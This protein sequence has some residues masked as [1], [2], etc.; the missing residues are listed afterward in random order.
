MT[1]PTL[2]GFTPAITFD[3]NT[4]N[5]TPQ[6]LDSDVNFQ[7][8]EGDFTGGQLTL[9]GLLAEDR[10]SV[11]NEGVDAGQIG[12]S[13]T[14]VT[15]GGV[16]IGTLAGG[17]GATLTITFNASAT[18]A[19]IDA[20]IQN[21]T[22]ANVSNAPTASRNLILNVI[23][24]AGNG[25]GSAAGTSQTF[26]QQS[27]AGDP[28]GG[29]SSIGSRGTPSFGDVDGDGDLDMVLGRGYGY[30]GGTNLRYFTNS[31]GVFTEQ[32]GAQNPFRAI[33][34]NNYSDPALADLDGD[35][36]LDL[37]VHRQYSNSRTFFNTGGVFTERT[38]SQNPLN[39]FS[40]NYRASPTFVDFDGD[41]D[42]D[43]V[44][45]NGGSLRYFQNNAN[46]FTEQ[47]GSTNPFNGDNFGYNVSPAFI[48][49]DGDG[50]LDVVA[51]QSNGPIR[52]F[53]NNGNGSFS[54]LSG[55][56][57]PFNGA[58]FAG[59]APTFADVDNDGDLDL[60]VGG[61][62]QIVYFLNTSPRGQTV[63][64][65]VTA[66]N[67]AL[68]ATGLPTDVTVIE[69]TSSNLNLS[70]LSL[71]DPDVVAPITMVLTA[72][73]GTLTAVSGGGVTVTGS[74]S[75]VLTLVGTASAIDTFLNT[76]TNVRY[77]SAA[78][79]AGDN[80]ATVTV[81]VDEGSGPVEVGVVN[82][83]ITNTPEPP[84][85]TGFATAVTFNENDVNATPALID[86]EVDF[87]DFEGTFSGGSL[88]M[89]GL[90]A[91]DRV[92]VRNEGV[93]AGQIGLSGANVTYGGVVIGTLAGGSGVTLTI[94]FNA[95]ADNAAVD[96]LI[97]NLTYANVSNNPTATRNLALN[98]TDAD[99]LAITP[100][101][102][103]GPATFSVQSGAS[104]P[105]NAIT[106]NQNSG[107]TFFDIDN[108]GDGDLIVGTRDGF[109][110]AYTN[111]NGTFTERTGS[112]NPFNGVDIG[113]Y[114]RP[115]F[116]DFDGD[117]DLDMV[118]GQN[119]SSLRAFR[120]TNGVFAEVSGGSNPFNGISASNGTPTF[121]DIDSDGDQ[122]LV[123]GSSSSQLRVFTNANNVFTER[124]GTNNPLN[125]ISEYRGAPT[126]VDL[127]GD[128]DRDLVLGTEAGTLR[129]F[130]NASNVFTEQTG[131]ANP[132]NGIDIGSRSAPAFSDVDADGDQDLVIGN[133][134]GT[135]T[136][137]LNT[138][139]R[140][141]V[142]T[143]TVTAQND[144]LTVTGLPTDVTVIEDL[145]SNLNLS[146][147]T[148]TDPD[149][150]A[151]ITMVLTA[152][153]GTLAAVSNGGVTVTGS[154]TGVLTLVGTASA[155]DTFLNTVT[156]IRYTG[157]A[158]DAGADAAT[159]TV[160]IDEGAGAYQVG[161]V[162]VDITDMPEPPVLTG[163]ATTVTFG[164]NDVNATP[165]LLDIDVSFSDF[166]DTFTGGTLR[167]AGLLAE[168]R[169]SVRNEGVDAGQIGLSGSNVTYGGVVIGTLAGGSGATLT[170]TFNAA[171]NSV[172]IDALIQNL[173]YANVSNNPTATRN[174]SLNVTDAGGLSI[175]S[176][177]SAGAATFAQQ[178]GAANPFN[179]VS[180]SSTATPFFGDFDNDGDQD[181]VVGST[182]NNFRYFTSVG[183]VFTERTGAQ[184]PFNGISNSGGFTDG[185][186]V[187]LDADGDLDFFQNNRDNGAPRTWFNANGVLTERT[188][189]Q[190]PFS[191]I[192]LTL[193][194]RGSPTFVD[195]D[196]D[197]DMDLVT[198]NG[199]SG[200]RTFFNTGGAFAE[201][202]GAS[203]PFNG[204][205][206]GS[207]QVSPTFLDLDGD[208]DL[209]VVS[210]QYT[211]LLRT[212]RN[213]GSGS[214]T[215]LTG[216][217]N[218][219][220]GVD[221]GDRAAPTFADVDGDG[222]MDL[223]T[224]G[225]YGPNSN[226]LI[227]HLNTTP[228]GQI[229]TVNV[230]A[231][232]D[233]LT[234]TGLPTD[235]TVIEEIASNVNLSGLT[236]TD[237]DVT[238]NITMVLTASEGTLTAVSGGGVTVTGSASGV[239]TLIG[240]ASAIDTFLNTVTNI[241]YTGATDDQGDNAATITVTIDEGAGAYAVGVVNVDIT[242]TTEAPILT[243]L[244]TAVTFG[245]N[246]VNAT[247]ALI[248]AEVDFSDFEGTFS[249][250]SLRMAGIL[251]EDRVSVRN[252][253]VDA[254][255]IGLSGAN[256]TYGGVVIG[257]LAGGSGNTLTITFNAAANSAAVDALVQNLTYANVS[258]TPTATRNFSLNITDADGQNI[259]GT[260]SVGTATF[261]QQ[262]GAANPF[263]AV[264]ASNRSA[265]TLAD[266]DADGDLDLVMGD[267][268]GQVRYYNNAGGVY[269]ERTGAQNPF[270]GISTGNFSDTAFADLDGDGDLDMVVHHRYSNSRSFFNT[271]GV[272]AE[273]TGSQNP[274]N[275]FSGGYRAS[276]VFVDFDGDGDQDYVLGNGSQLRYFRNT[277]NVFSEQS[278]TN[279]PFGTLNFGNN[280]SPAFMDLDSD[281]DLDV[282]AGQ[283][284]G[285]FRS[286]RN[287]GSGSFT[288]LTGAANPFNGIDVGDNASPFFAD[289]D[290]DGDLD[291]VSGSNNGTPT[292][293][294]NTSPRGQIIAVNVTAQNDALTATGLPTDVTVIEEIASNVNLSALTLTDL[295]V[296]D[297][298]TVVLTAS[299]GILTAGS[300]GG[301]TVTG[302]ASGT[303][304]LVG[305]AAAIDTFLNNVAAIR[306][307]GASNVDGD[308]AATVTVTTNEG[309][310]AVTVGVVNV[311]ITNT[312]EAPVLTGFATTL[313][314]AENTANVTPQLLDIDVTFS[315][316]EDTFA[317]GFL[318]M[319]GLLA[320]DR[321]SVRN[322]GVDAGQIGLSGANVTYGG[323]VI[324]TLAGGS[325]NALTITFN[326]AAN[327]VAIDALI[328][329]LTY[330]NV[331]DNPT[332][333]RNLALNIT[334]ADGQT[335]VG[336]G[337]A[338]NL[339]F[340]QQSGSGNPFGGI[341]SV[342]NRATPSF[343]DVDG[344]GDLDMVLNRG[345]GYGNLR[346]FTN[347]GGVFTEQSGAQNPFG[348]IPGSNYSDPVLADLDGDGDLDLVVHVRYSNS[349]TFFN[350]GGVFTERTGSQNPLN[351]FS[352]NYRASPTFV[353][354]D[355]D[356]DQDYV[357][358]NGNQLRYFQNNANVF[359]EQSGAGNPFNGDTFGGS[360]ISPA[361]IDLDGD[362]DLDVVAGQ[363]YG[364]IRVFR[365]EGNGTFAEQT[366][367]ANPFN[368][369]SLSSGAAPTFADID[370]DG[371]LDLVVGSSNSISY[372]LNTS[373]RGQIVTVNV[374]TEADAVTATGVPTDVTVVE[375]VASN[376]NLSA[377]ALTDPDVIG[378]ITVV[379][380]ASAGTMVAVTG[381]GV[382]VTGSA[383]GVL[384]LVGTTAAIDAFLNT[385]ANIRYTGAANVFGDNAATVTITADGGTGAVTLGVVNVDITAV[386]DAPTLSG[387]GPINTFIENATNAGPQLLDLDV[388]FSDLEDGFA[389][390]A[391]TLSGLL[392]EDRVS[393]RNEGTDAGQIG[394]SGTDVTYGG[395]VI[396]TLAGGS[397]ATLTITFNAAADS[398]SI[399][400]LI[401]NLTYANASDNP[402]TSRNLVLN[403]TDA[404]GLGLTG[405]GRLSTF[406]Q[407]TGVSNP[408]NGSPINFAN[409]NSFIDLD[410]DGDL[411]LVT[412][413]YNGR[414]RAFTNSAGAFTELTGSA[415]PFNAIDV[416]YNS[417]P[418]FADLDGD[419]D[420]DLVVGTN[421]GTLRTFTNSGGAFSEVTGAANP[422][423]G[424][425]LGSHTTPTF[426][427]VD[428]DGDMDL[429]VGNNYG[430]TNYFQNTTPRPSAST[431]TVNVA[432]QNDAP[433][434][435]GLPTDVTV[436][437]DETSALDLSA[438][439]LTDV[440]TSGPITVVLAASSGTLAAAS[441]SGVTVSG[442]ATGTLTLVGT[443]A[444]ID[445]FLNLAS[446]VQ[447][448]AVIG[449]S[450]NNAAT[451]IITANDGGGAVS[452][453]TVNIDITT[454]DDLLIGTAGADTLNGL[455]GNDILRGLGGIDILNGGT[456]IDLAD[457]S[458][459]A[460][461]VSVRLAS[462]ATLADG[463]G[464]RDTLNSIENVTG[465]A[466]DDTLFGDGVDNVLLGG[467]G[468]DTLL[469]LGGNDTLSG[470]TGVAN[471]L[472]G[473]LGDDIY[474]VE[475][476]DTITEFA[477]EGVD[478]VRTSL[479]TFT[480]GANLENLTYSGA[481]LFRGTGNALANVITGGNG[482]DVLIG[483]GGVD[484]LNGGGGID[485]VDYSTAAA[486]VTA[487]LT[488]GTAT[489]DGD[490]A[491][492]TLTGIE[493]LT[494][495][496]FGDTLTG[497]A[498]S[499]VL[500]GGNGD[501]VLTG[502]SG[503]DFLFGGAGVDTASWAGASSGVRAAINS[504]VLGDGSASDDGDGGIDSLSGIENLIGSDF[505]D[506]LLGSAA[507]NV[508]TGGLGA[509]LLL[510]FGGND[511]LI[512]GTGAANTLQGGLGDD[513]YVVSAADTITEVANEGNDT[514]Q[515]DRASFNLGANLENLTYTGSG[516][517][518]GTG[519]VLANVI[520]GGSGADSLRGGGGDDTL[521]GGLG[522]DLVLV[523]GL[524]ADYLIQD[525]GGGQFRVTD[526]VGGRDGIDILT[527]VE[528]IRF[529][530]GTTV[531]LSSLV[532]APSLSPKDQAT[533]FVLPGLTDDDFLP[534]GKDFGDPLVLPG[535]DGAP[536]RIA[537][538]P[539]TGDWM[540]T[541][542]DTDPAIY[543][544]GDPAARPFHDDWMY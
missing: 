222:D 240:T 279:N 417:D 249:G 85:L 468:R 136:Y 131:S 260:G 81:T 426:Q 227:F 463:D 203:N 102:S 339:T 421:Y 446:R 457:Y 293:Y 90:L 414:L 538:T 48:D 360:N 380:T 30:I 374:T 127:D 337:S 540:L 49:L 386:N 58:S 130:F 183:G 493:N 529:S 258:H 348:S 513:I 68:T 452:L 387:F 75:G 382:T 485:L 405:A 368:G 73:E 33:Q 88:R 467:L 101:G 451:L 142:V 61:N 503:N 56:A 352:G 366:G 440:D 357:L 265:P 72:S 160:T 518:G 332:A 150:I 165:A 477:N 53:Q 254:G 184:N 257:T 10:V 20:L 377:I 489:N 55:T 220:N 139:P 327:S 109:F 480:L 5:S 113:Y 27:G 351:G 108:D 236:L 531:A 193:S 64:V 255:Q 170:I 92:S 383:S 329:N 19:A 312:T 164:E 495:S 533:A 95:A 330:A 233:A 241:R 37:V 47:S 277:S 158:N 230:T 41:G 110:R 309:S 14:D 501:D 246:D 272:F 231:Q 342:G 247:P 512:G 530:N 135:L 415:N 89:A 29:I 2:T 132:F 372:F 423:D 228:R 340:A 146:G 192:G 250:G 129:T 248:D 235:V 515:T 314:F 239:L 152:S 410:G 390:G 9:S 149:V 345:G 483:R 7:D 182:A 456:G 322:E 263:N 143:V 438:L 315:D 412:G 487:S 46:V 283:T 62:N 204:V 15:Y 461:G 326:A 439:S 444:A 178:T 45:S 252:E 534:T 516:N 24:A 167:L 245:E 86:A 40:G 36:D 428:G 313:T 140:G 179:G 196:G 334:D 194:Y 413:S 499:N 505:D 284:E 25:F 306:Y 472:Q 141:Q 289:V 394:L 526:N 276:P 77:T 35:G 464:G 537:I 111:T 32:T 544:G 43:Y 122:D 259:G 125:G 270:N 163:L 486:G 364:N 162:N 79:D 523:S 172:A 21:L 408:F 166:E 425:D 201:R 403:V 411:D 459:A 331:S 447:Y 114:A 144:A 449:V 488:D 388:S 510:G 450:G 299:T 173:T 34:G 525:L 198:N 432:P 292:Y 103:A 74:A 216:S 4:L 169:V 267:V 422:F 385:P 528:S 462:R 355:G 335:L 153:E 134:T 511:I 195:L 224:G 39:G 336:N 1:A 454:S 12:L 396:G 151:P 354:F 117:G 6:L 261:A 478:T 199:G 69:D 13:G 200:L 474:I 238:P 522:S 416:G 471:T 244:V 429:L 229:V 78:N 42:R 400:A 96:A 343:G 59:P 431:I 116:V 91:E 214:F 532:A 97:Q 211:G 266:V 319:S 527:G 465:S 174:L 191:S 226:A 219:F 543:P 520:T 280:V 358:S 197:G 479:T 159:V 268:N 52:S 369:V 83:D 107:P 435:T 217:A 185:A 63:T 424:V 317:G 482:R 325:G 507:A 23:D 376:L 57:N 517:F 50:D 147:L 225:A 215:E 281:G 186:L 256:V 381:G 497:D 187:D 541:L 209:D 460:A 212:F 282:V 402:T 133:Q 145:A 210:G 271:G 296:N 275:G 418:A 28:F 44:L 297:S 269:T 398:V 437:G 458:T 206:F 406:A 118:T 16:V 18:S 180:F 466:F 156:N 300:S 378:N 66:Q 476:A 155:I 234:A 469:G 419:G 154:A 365:N 455:S 427:D 384:T 524:S 177:G 536:D 448:T 362:G 38:G 407:L 181:M 443:A 484:A 205:S 120:N 393:V 344:D 189:A 112:A 397:G 392:A 298:L 76:V 436:A 498:G 349:R 506:T 161:V 361:F 445:T 475:A 273:R 223:V 323:V 353:D 171:A 84:V 310:G 264:S 504:G 379:L 508:L 514:V 324:G 399:D 98:I 70:A 106:V 375:D 232:N 115:V 373:P 190:N 347:S 119:S 356:G 404:D 302:S 401:Q 213:N 288:E 54:E 94:T 494:G 138:T 80:A 301:V 22:Y 262:T 168:D 539:Q 121:T 3:E 391:L 207:G 221:V 453:G 338:G 328:Q 502:R 350:T 367:T 521:N 104:N 304:T 363:N 291:L 442:S 287:N 208:G 128:G 202:T 243:G 370:N 99:G 278:G 126:F 137:Y 359:T 519:N 87:S 481:S 100:S 294:L 51:G 492:D 321:V 311:D 303:L 82:L 535:A 490:G 320:E 253:G 496:A 389:G 60:V 500:I 218:P 318:R 473:G 11:R 371:D 491:S 305:T 105:F 242:N 308:N 316:F 251:A 290:N 188:G 8:A 123:F 307:T 157:A 274:L 175:A 237:P 433:V 509:D 434:A 176:T 409:N 124:T 67:D 420:Q 333:T 470:G 17:S 148:L 93:D 26:V 441:A 430:V 65:N 286:Y 295:D 542:T 395:V 285:T 341:S 71:R 346:Y 31:G